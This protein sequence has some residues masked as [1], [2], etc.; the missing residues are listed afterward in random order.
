MAGAMPPHVVPTPQPTALDASTSSSPGKSPSPGLDR[1]GLV[2]YAAIVV[3]WGTSWIMIRYALGVTPV[4]VTVALRFW[5]AAA[6]M[7]AIL[8]I[9]G[10]RWRFSAA[11]HAL[12]VV[13]GV[14]L[15]STNF[16]LFYYAGKSLT[17]GLLAVIFSMAT[18]YNMA[19]SV[20][21]ERIEVPRR[22]LLG[23]M[24]GV[25]GLCLIFWPELRA[26][27]SAAPAVG[28]ALLGTLSFSIGNVIAQRVRVRGLPVIG[29]TAWGMLYGASGLSLV[30]F[31][32]WA[33]G[34]IDVVIDTRPAYWASLVAQAIFA[35]VIAFLTYTALL[36]RIGTARAGYATVMF[37]LI[38]LAISTSVEGYIWTLA[39]VAGLGL[40]LAGNIAVL[41]K[42]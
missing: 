20:V 39:S 1:T 41:R 34:T 16:T 11:D 19:L 33:T 3:V 5:L 14:F 36:R 42:S 7:F 18:L 17:T 37:P 22:V 10:E 40:I 28:L 27:R 24:L 15:F 12:L 32:L 29:S 38:A 35:S 8:A 13:L 30:A 26:D 25:A 9:R 31:A 23:G 21:A 6:L 2:L 4:E